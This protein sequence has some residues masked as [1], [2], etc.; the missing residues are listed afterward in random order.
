MDS[1]LPIVDAPLDSRPI[2]TDAEFA[3]DMIRSLVQNLPAVR[4]SASRIEK[5]TLSTNEHQSN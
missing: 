3:T 4:Q 5:E 1:S 2:P